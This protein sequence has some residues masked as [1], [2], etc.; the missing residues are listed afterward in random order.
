MDM[1]TDLATTPGP[2]TMPTAPS[3]LGIRVMLVDDHPVMRVGLAN[4]LSLNHGFAVVAQADDGPSAI[5][6]WRQHRPDVCLLDVSM[7]RMD[8]IET[9][10]RLRAE[11]PEA[12]V[13]MLTS[14]K[15][16]EDREMAM[17]SGACGYL[18]KTVR[19]D[20]LA[21]AI[22]RVHAGETLAVPLPPAGPPP[23]R[24][25]RLRTG[26][27]EAASPIIAALLPYR[28]P[29][30]A[31]SSSGMSLPRHGNRSDRASDTR[32]P[33]AVTP[34]PPYSA[35]MRDGSD[36]F[37]LD[38]GAVVCPGKE[39]LPIDPLRSRQRHGPQHMHRCR[40]NGR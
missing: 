23:R 17:Q 24:G 30:C 7:E 21:A 32:E 14:S 36:P 39:S 27:P 2:G 1:A 4:V 38:Q 37:D 40:E 16:P 35:S 10:R 29:T 19:H 8:G 3:P 5:A 26:H 33:S 13:I 34:P 20:E 18:L 31:A 11:F 9:L 15:A 12:R 28:S 6:L 25:D 22:R